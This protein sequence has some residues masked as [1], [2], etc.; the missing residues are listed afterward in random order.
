MR[1][2]D[3]RRDQ[4]VP[5]I[6]PLRQVRPL[7]RLLPTVERSLYGGNGKCTGCSDC[8]SKPES[9]QLSAAG[10][11][12]QGGPNVSPD[13]RARPSLRLGTRSVVLN[14]SRFCAL[15]TDATRPKFD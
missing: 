7:R 1:L 12:G 13:Q 5:L 15:A 2:V 3:G 11:I 4:G 8:E 14:L 6:P 10:K 9:S